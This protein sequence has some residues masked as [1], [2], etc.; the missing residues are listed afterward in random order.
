MEEALNAVEFEQPI[1]GLSVQGL[2]AP[3][4]RLTR[5][6]ARH[7]FRSQVTAGNRA[8]NAEKD[9]VGIA[10]GVDRIDKALSDVFGLAKLNDTGFGG[11][12][13]RSPKRLG[14]AF[15]TPTT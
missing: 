1:A 14:H 2:R 10:R 15:L 3:Q 7:Q 8:R 4:D 11:Q 6:W 5:Q 9:Q 12:S 13:I